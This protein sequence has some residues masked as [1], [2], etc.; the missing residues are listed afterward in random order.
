M[1]ALDG[2]LN[3]FDRRTGA[4]D[5]QVDVIDHRRGY[6]IAAAP[7]S[8]AAVNCCHRFVSP[9]LTVPIT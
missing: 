5:W 1:G 6:S 7:L 8:R 9:A 2:K 3:A 4:I